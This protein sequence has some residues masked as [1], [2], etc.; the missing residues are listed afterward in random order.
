MIFFSFFIVKN[1]GNKNWKNLLTKETL[2]KI[3]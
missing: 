1:N 3:I 2:S